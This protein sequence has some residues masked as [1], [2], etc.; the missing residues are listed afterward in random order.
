MIEEVYAETVE[1]GTSPGRSSSVRSKQLGR[2][3]MLLTPDEHGHTNLRLRRSDID[4]YE[5]GLRRQRV[6]TY[7]LMT[8]IVLAGAG[9]I[10]WAVMREPPPLEVEAEPNNDP[11]HTNKI[12]A[13]TEVTGYLGARM[14][15]QDGDRDFF[16][17]PWPA[18]SR[19]VV[20]VRVTGLPNIDVNLGVSDGDGMHVATSDEAGVGEGEVLHRRS[21]D[22]PLVIS[23]GETVP[24]DAK[25]PIENVSDP[26]TLTVIE[27]KLVGETEPNTNDA[28]AN[29]LE[30]TREMRGFLDARTDID[31]LRW[32]GDDGE[33]NIIVR[34]DGIPLVWRIGDGQ[35]RTPGAARVTLKRGDLIRL[36]RSDRTATTPLTGRDAMWSIVVMPGH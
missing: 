25:L 4:A 16:I 26:Y 32:T 14:S 18:G 22:G 36:E 27:E 8:V 21:I 9:G 7:V 12:A 20:T 5:R 19:R 35:M 13:N 29:P 24:K 1:L 15:M 11:A 10:A 17:V 2:R 6:L 23:V 30:L 28:D 3:S 31:Q 33:Y 34:A